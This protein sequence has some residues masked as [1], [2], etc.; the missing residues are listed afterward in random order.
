[1]ITKT[2]VRSPF[3]PG[4]LDAGAAPN[5]DPRRG[6]TVIQGFGPPTPAAQIVWL[7]RPREPNADPGRPVVVSVTPFTP[8]DA[9]A[10]WLTRPRD[11]QAPA[12]TDPRRPVMVAQS[13]APAPP[14]AVAVWVQPPRSL[15]GENTDPRRAVQVLG[16]P[17]TP[18]ASQVVWFKAPRDESV[19]MFAPWTRH[20]FTI[21][22]PDHSTTTTLGA[23]LSV[24]AEDRSSTTTLGASLTI[25]SEE[26]S[27]DA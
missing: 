7:T 16:T 1:M 13:P 19:V 15:D 23:S 5:T 6:P 25:A 8:P 10:L 18:P 11:E 9:Q 26:Y 3:M 20:T 14:A 4:P 27:S 17:F 12:N 22:A 21:P 24:P 2:G